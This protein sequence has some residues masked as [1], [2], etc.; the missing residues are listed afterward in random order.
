MTWWVPRQC[1]KHQAPSTPRAVPEGWGCWSGRHY[2]PVARGSLSQFRSWDPPPTRPGLGG[3]HKAPLFLPW[4]EWIGGSRIG[5]QPATPE[6]PRVRQREGGQVEDGWMEAMQGSGETHSCASQGVVAPAAPAGNQLPLPTP[7][8]PHGCTGQPWRCSH[9]TLGTAPGPGFQLVPGSPGSDVRTPCG[10][11]GPLALFAGDGKLEK[12]ILQQ[13][14]Q[15]EEASI[16]CRERSC[17]I[18]AASVRSHFMAS[19]F[20]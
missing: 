5:C 19:Q 11:H 4:N 12:Q 20:C 8:Q 6:T 3:A 1:G 16:A 2:T 18:W 10:W 17:R 9:S 14:S 13:A 15:V 7:C